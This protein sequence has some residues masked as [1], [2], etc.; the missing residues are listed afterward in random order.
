LPAKNQLRLREDGEIKPLP[1]LKMIIDRPLVSIVTPSFNSRKYIEETIKSVKRQD[2]P[3]IEHIIVDG[4]STDGTK[5]IL[6]EYT[7]QIKWLSEPDEGMYDA[8]NKGFSM[9]MG[10]IF[11][12]INADDCYYSFDSVSQ[13]VRA[14]LEAPGIDF[15]YGHCAFGDE[16]GEI[17][18]VYRAPVFNR[19]LATAFPR[20]IFH[21]PTCF[22]RKR[23]HIG[24]DSSF[25]YCGDSNF[26]RYLCRHHIGKNTK[27]IIAKF[28]L[29]RDN[30]ASLNKKDMAKEDERVFGKLTD[31]KIALHL[32]IIDLVY[33]R[34]FLNLFANLKRFSLHRQGRPYL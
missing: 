16:G 34:T 27:K 11:T 8:I 13:M 7:G 18:Y 32:R 29:R 28:M 24:F 15:A 10:E 30:I 22:W 33:I 14:F 1:G 17:L 3:N 26:F 21:Q 5:E 4:A 6:M 25:K 9:A 23:V 31:R 12:Y 19:R 20:I 2:Y